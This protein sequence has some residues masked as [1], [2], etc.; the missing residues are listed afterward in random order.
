[1]KLVTFLYEEE[2]KWGVLQD[3]N[4]YDLS[5][6]VPGT[7]LTLLK[8]GRAGMLA[9][10]NGISYVR[11]VPIDDVTWLPPVTNPGKVLAIGKNYHDHVTETNSV[12]PSYPMIFGK[13][14]S[15][16]TGHNQPIV[17]PLMVEKADYEG[18]LVVVIGRDC[19]NV[20]ENDALDY[21]A[22]YTV[23]ND[24]SAR[25]WQS[26]TSQFASGKMIDTFG[27]VGPALV[28]PEAISNVQNLSIRTW[29]NGELRQDSN[30]HN[31]IFSVAYIISY[32]SQ[33]VTLHVGDMIFTGTPD[34]VGIGR[35]PAQF[36]QSGDRV[37][38][39]I[40]EIGRLVN[41]CTTS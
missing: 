40:E 34:G 31:M 37:E 1:M 26:R 29:V 11:P 21:V 8:R 4:L 23:G 25:D 30:T 38:V 36:L 9:A 22:G 10:Q 24:V 5:P 18:E 33:I 12:P 13:T 2:K 16:L 7:L 32:L 39:E 27:P 41:H 3:G 20:S 17:I 6:M 15:S 14:P 35:N 28:T 19:K